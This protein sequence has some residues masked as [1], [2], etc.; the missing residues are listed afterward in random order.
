[1]YFY[2]DAVTL[3]A[4]C[5]LTDF[6]Y[7]DFEPSAHLNFVLVRQERLTKIARNRLIHGGQSM[8]SLHT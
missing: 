8:D 4:D 3:P 7:L 6:D 1:M 5:F 2:R